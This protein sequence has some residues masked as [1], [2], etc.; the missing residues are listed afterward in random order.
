MT[1]VVRSIPQGKTGDASGLPDM[2]GAWIIR[3]PIEAALQLVQ[4]GHLVNGT[5]SNAELEGTMQGT[6]FKEKEDLI[7][8]GKWADQL[9][10]GDFRVFIGS[11]CRNRDEA[12]VGRTI[13]RGMWKY[14]QSQIWNGEFVG[15]KR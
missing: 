9:G 5:Y 11:T 15:E 8:I 6:L 7:F 13:F 2:R 12:V 14:S 1:C 3:E 10:R 4:S